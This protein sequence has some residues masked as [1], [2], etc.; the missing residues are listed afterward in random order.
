MDKTNFRRGH[1]QKKN[2]ITDIRTMQITY[3]KIHLNMPSSFREGIGSK[4]QLLC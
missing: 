4:Q 1:H 2:K 3:T